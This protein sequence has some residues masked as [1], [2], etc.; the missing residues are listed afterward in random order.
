MQTRKHR[1]L[2]LSL[3]RRLGLQPGLVLGCL[4]LC[5]PA[6]LGSH[7]VRSDRDRQVFAALKRAWLACCDAGH[8]IA[9][10]DDFGA[11]LE[12]RLPLIEQAQ[13]TPLPSA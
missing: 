7:F 5:L 10:L 8:R 1:C 13:H 3:S 6:L 9:H 12:V 11:V 4:P 2:C